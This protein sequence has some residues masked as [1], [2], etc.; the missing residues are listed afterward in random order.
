[1]QFS[2]A[3]EFREI[4][5]KQCLSYDFCCYFLNKI[6]KKKITN[7]LKNFFNKKKKKKKKKNTKKKHAGNIKKQN[8]NVRMFDK[9]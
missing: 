1:M 4:I 7:V 2:I 6:I 3:W 9:I 5:D 8:K